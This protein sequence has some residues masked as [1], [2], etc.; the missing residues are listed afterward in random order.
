MYGE[1]HLSRRELRSCMD[2]GKAL[3][4][5]LDQ[6]RLFGT[7]LKKL[8]D[9]IP[10][11]IWSLMLVEREKNELVFKLS[12]DLDMK[13]VKDIRIAMGQGIAGQVALTKTPMVVDDVRTCKYFND[14]IDR[15][16]GKVTKSVMCVPL[17]F[18]NQAV[19]VIEAINP[20]K[21]SKKALSL[22]M[23]VADYAAIAVENTRHY[24]HI[25][26]LANK[27][28][29]TGLYNTRYLYSRL[30]ELFETSKNTNKPFGLIFM[31]LDNFKKIVDAHGHL[32]GSQ[33]IQEVA[34]TIIEALSE[35]AFGVSYGGDEFVI[36]L[37]G[38]DRKATI[39]KAEE[40]RS[41]MVKTVY[42]SNR[43][44]NARLSASFGVAAYPED[45][46]NLTRLLSVADKAMFNI[47][48]KGKNAVG[49]LF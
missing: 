29:L 25:Q 15:I 21:T 42:L 12:I 48:D 7:I 8:S 11:D 41:L 23:F 1:M 37:P 2:L 49:A 17:V 34:H 27:D 45:A 28:N 14:Q 22:L 13:E 30:S 26:T 40:I 19:G 3:T 33:A 9:L 47:K 46:T 35:P 6:N 10:A 36:V 39:D 44:I 43:G 24:Q 31:D 16:S 18:G 38:F 20:Y 4:S 5:E 32:N